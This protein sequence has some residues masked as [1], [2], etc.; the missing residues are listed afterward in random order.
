[1]VIMAYPSL[2][3]FAAMLALA[4]APALAQTPAPPPVDPALPARLNELKD[5]VK[6]KSMEK[7]FPAI[8]SIQNLAKDL[9]KKNPKDVQKI[10]KALGDVFRT[11]K[12]RTGGK[13][14]LYRE[15][16]NALAKFEEEGAKALLKAAEDKRFDDNLALR[17]H[18][19]LALGKTQDQKQVNYLLEVMTRSPHDELRAAS[20]EALG[21]FKNA[22]INQQRDIVKEIIKAW[23]SLESLANQAVNNSSNGPQ[24]FGPENARRTLRAVESKWVGTLQKL[25]GVSQ[26]KFL[27]WQHWQN[28]NKNWEPPK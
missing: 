19:I 2:V 18:L 8:G 12:L 20:G 9:D 7:D 15:T 16:A 11:G 21:N 24:D 5:M 14:I 22:K 17:A 28:K 6:D 4:S 10:A 27:E 3:K 23:G 25:T 26:S 13:D 1:M